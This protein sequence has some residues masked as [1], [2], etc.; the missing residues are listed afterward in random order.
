MDG[1]RTAMRRH[2]PIAGAGMIEGDYNDL[3][4]FRYLSADKFHEFADWAKTLKLTDNEYKRLLFD[5]ARMCETHLTRAEVEEFFRRVGAS[6][7]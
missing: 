3:I 1:E 2:A 5:W 4:P 7:P 6:V